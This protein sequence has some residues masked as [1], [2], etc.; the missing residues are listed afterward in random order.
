MYE[1]AQSKKQEEEVVKNE[2]R[3]RGYLSEEVFPS[4]ALIRD[5]L[6]GRRIPVWGRDQYSEFPKKFGELYFS[7]DAG[8]FQY[9]AAS[10]QE[11]F[12]DERVMREV[13]KTV[14]YNSTNYWVN[15]SDRPKNIL[16]PIME[17]FGI[18]NSGLV[19][20]DKET[21][22]TLDSKKQKILDRFKG[23]Y[24][25][26][27]DKYIEA[28]RVYPKIFDDVSGILRLSARNIDKAV[29]MEANGTREG[30]GRRYLKQFRD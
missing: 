5:M 15:A 8:C 18:R 10:F 26:L 17:Y 14:D 30:D 9:N 27:V 6:A 20:G 13:N 4:I 25:I 19:L 22:Y 16:L 3:E 1:L 23:Q 11:R 2:D 12:S 29:E 28:K 24:D 7:E 21:G